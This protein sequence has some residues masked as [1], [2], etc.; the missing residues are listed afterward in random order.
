MKKYIIPAGF[1]LLIG[2]NAVFNGGKQAQGRQLKFQADDSTHRR[3]NGAYD[4]SET[5]VPATY[6]H[7]K[8]V[9]DPIAPS[10]QPV[11][12]YIGKCGG[13]T[14]ASIVAKCLGVVQCSP[15]GDSTGK[16]IP[17]APGVEVII[18]DDDQGKYLN[19][20]P[21]SSQ[22]MALL[23]STNVVGNRQADII[24]TPRV[25]DA[26]NLMT[27]HNKGRFMVMFRHPVSIALSCLVG[28]DIHCEP[29]PHNSLSRSREKST[30]FTIDKPRRGILTSTLSWPRCPSTITLT[31]ISSWTTS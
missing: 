12:W 7:T 26:G 14:F 13:A 20:N 1:I 21:V 10:D 9:W 8:N 17:S 25:A 23:A 16:I 6:V 22:G 2:L 24:I 28:N 31:L 5:E 19:I 4:I 15:K 29:Y 3:L 11:F 27:E 18:H 30:C